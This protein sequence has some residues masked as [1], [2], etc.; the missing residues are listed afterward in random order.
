MAKKNKFPIKG[1]GIISTVAVI[2]IVAVIFVDPFDFVLEQFDPFAGFV[3]PFG[4]DLD[5]INE[6]NEMI[7]EEILNE[8][9]ECDAEMFALEPEI[10]AE[11]LEMI[12]EKEG[13]LIIIEP[14]NM[15]E[16]S[17]DPPIVQICDELDLGCGS[18]IMELKATI[19]KINALGN[20][21]VITESFGIPALDIGFLADPTDFDLRNGQLELELELNTK[22]SAS[23]TSNGLFE[24]FLNGQSVLAEPIPVRGNGISDENGI[25]PMQFISPTGIASNTYTFDFGFNFDKFV[26]EQ[27][28]PL[29]LR[30]LS[31]EVSRNGDMFAIL[32]QTVI[33]L[34]IE[35]DDIKILVIN[36]EFGTFDRVYP[37][38][39][40]IIV[41]T[42]AKTLKS[43][44]GA[45]AGRIVTTAPPPQIGRI[46]V[47]D[48]N[49]DLVVFSNGGSGVGVLDDLVT[50]N[51]NYTMTIFFPS[52]Q[53]FLQYGKAQETKSFSCNSELKSN[54]CTIS[55]STQI[56]AGGSRWT[57]CRD[58]VSSF[59][60]NPIPFCNLP[61]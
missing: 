51:A 37:A 22:R 2:A 39:S 7:M 47:L 38:D 1:V 48:A 61:K 45:C 60:I 8:F 53:T 44:S 56:K 46:D 40:R 15:T 17:E 19:T 32:N 24:V 41:N 52:D 59:V 11:D 14:M 29:E 27:I 43:I 30:L 6:H 26:N 57:H 42:V 18:E 35:R 16:F 33:N 12:E 13:E 5:A 31:Y 25:L 9:G 21:T 3:I 28:N 34:D 10:C 50:R 36:E 4:G 23:I 49:G 54:T 55:C 20:Q 58:V